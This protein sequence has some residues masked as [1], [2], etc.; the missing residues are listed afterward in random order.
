MFVLHYTAQY[1]LYRLCLSLSA[2]ESVSM[3]V[4]YLAACR[5]CPYLS[6][7]FA[8]SLYLRV[9]VFLSVSLSTYVLSRQYV[10]LP[11]SATH[12]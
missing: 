10:C 9:S 3:S 12:L 5:L 1:T 11:L 6:F 4:F 7:A 2:F 8:I